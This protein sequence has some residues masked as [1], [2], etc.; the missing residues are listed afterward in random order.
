M[1][2]GQEMIHRVG[3]RCQ[4]F[5]EATLERSRVNRIAVG[6]V[7]GLILGLLVGGYLV[8]SS[9]AVLMPAL[10]TALLGG[11]IGFLAE[12]ALPAAVM[13]LGGAA[14]GALTYWIDGRQAGETNASLLI[15][16][17][18]GLWI[19]AVVSVRGRARRD[20]AGKI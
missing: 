16:A 7:A 6:A 3:R 8:G 1:G 4:W 17:L 5:V 18:V 20:A 14:P 11:I 12:R 10:L 13:F 9:N 15:G 19:A 2:R